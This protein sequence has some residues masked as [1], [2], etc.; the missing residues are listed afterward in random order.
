M[1]HT[2]R[3]G[4]LNNSYSARTQGNVRNEISTIPIQQLLL[5]SVN[6]FSGCG[7]TF[8]ETEDRHFGTQYGKLN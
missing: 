4:C 6:V 5:V 7:E 3:K 2:E 8:L 1:G